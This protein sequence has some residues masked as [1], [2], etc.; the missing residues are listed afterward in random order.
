MWVAQAKFDLDTITNAS[1]QANGNPKAYND[2]D[3]MSFT[4][5]ILQFDTV[6][7]PDTEAAPD[8]VH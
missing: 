7:A 6:A 1:F 2:F 5:A 8:T 4:V 3:I